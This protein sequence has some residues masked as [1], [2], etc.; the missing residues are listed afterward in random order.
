MKKA[1]TILLVLT[2]YLASAQTVYTKDGVPLGD[3]D[4]WS[5]RV[6]QRQMPP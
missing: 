6:K 4:F 2:G 1:L 3:G 5:V